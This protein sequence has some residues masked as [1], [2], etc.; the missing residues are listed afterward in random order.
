[1]ITAAAARPVGR[2]M[3]ADVE[4]CLYGR[5]L[6]FPVNLSARSF[7]R[8]WSAPKFPIEMMESDAIQIKG[9]T[10]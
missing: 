5:P 1:V 10:L 4:A 7:R 3:R 2:G 9:M 8:V 6:A